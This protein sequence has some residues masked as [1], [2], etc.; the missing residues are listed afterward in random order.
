MRAPHHAQWRKSSRSGAGNACVEIA[1]L[2]NGDRAVRDSKDR[3]SPV[4][5]F[6]A[7]QWT[8]FTTGVRA[9][10]RRAALPGQHPVDNQALAREGCP[11][12]TTLWPGAGRG[13]P[14]SARWE[15]VAH[16][17]TLNPLGRR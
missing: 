16:S 13:T 10:D 2:T 11:L 7:A 15:E 8:A 1:E 14:V 17:G 5:R 12:W 3:S 4:L 6:T 9:N